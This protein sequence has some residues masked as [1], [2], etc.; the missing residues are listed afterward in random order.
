MEKKPL[1]S[2]IALRSRPPRRPR[3]WLPAVDRTGDPPPCAC[4]TRR[5][6]PSCTVTSVSWMR[7]T[8]LPKSSWS[9]SV[10]AMRASV[11]AFSASVRQDLRILALV[12][13]EAVVDVAMGLEAVG[14]LLADGRR[15]GSRGPAEES[16]TEV[17]ARGGDAAEENGRGDE[18][19][20]KKSFA[21]CSSDS[22]GAGSQSSQR[23]RAGSRDHRRDGGGADREHP[24]SDP[25]QG[26]R[27]AHPDGQGHGEDEA[28]DLLCPP[29][30]EGVA[31]PWREGF[32][33][34]ADDRGHD[35]GRHEPRH[36]RSA[37]RSSAAA[38]AQRSRRR[39][40]RGRAWQRSL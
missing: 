14:A 35:E 33:G 19:A 4:S 27:I 30:G 20:A 11:K 37:L 18:A 34:R 8:S 32:A 39:A 22:S 31:A 5:G 7:E 38:A 3:R 28:L 23:T 25:D 36:A 10:G 26:R 9:A 1:P 40:R 29:R 15:C 6:R 17:E 12:E 21:W 2:A 16:S 24:R 13:P